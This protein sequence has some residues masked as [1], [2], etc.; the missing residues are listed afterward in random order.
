MSIF[1]F[2]MNIPKEIKN[3][4][5]KVK[6]AGFEIFVVGGSVRDLL[7]EKSDT[8]DWDLTTNAKPDEIL[9]IF[10]EG[11]YE[12]DFGTVL[13][14]IKSD[15]DEVMFVVEITTYRSE[16]GYSDRRHPDEV[17]FEEK[18]END[19]S[20]RDFTVNAIAWDGE[21]GEIIDLFGGKKD[22]RKKVIR[23]VGEPVDRFKED[24]LRMMRAIRFACQLGF[25][26]EEKTARGISKMAG[27]IKFI[28]KER[29]RDELVKILKSDKAYVG[30]M[31]LHDYKLLQYIIP[32]LEQGVGMEQNHHH[33]YSVFEHLALA[34]K[35]CPNKDW[36]VRFTAL[37]HDIGKPKTR[38]VVDGVVTFYNHEY[39]GAR[40]T[41]KILSRLK[42]SAADT[43]K[44]V[45]LVRNHM[46]YYNVG[47]VTESSVRRLIS[48]VGKEN[49]KDL[50][51]LRIAD[52]LGSGV[53]KAKPYKLRHLEYIM[54]KVQNDPV[55]VK[56]LKLNGDYMI[57]NLGF[58]PGPKMGAVLD[59]LLSE[60]LD[61]PARNTLDYLSQRALQLEQEDFN[62]LR[63]KAREAIGEKREEDDR[64][65]KRNYYVK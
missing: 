51:D 26:L 57:A 12:N 58:A 18:L 4:I 39:A 27:S 63:E 55:S 30:F 25:T 19:L 10:P 36:R 21:K 47:Q 13:V 33:T 42:F 11:K 44:I 40:M 9:K 8:G 24:A 59:I 37:L 65:I 52:R 61:D 54:E 16:S 48:K 46:F 23:A 6:T 60:V 20:R 34:L 28:A 22:I 49:L 17:V 38:K 53:P 31:M 3:I 50:I 14:P 62:A 5:N 29:I 32:E 56:M 35:N 64:K 2:I 43:E 15:T 7:L 41:E 45:N 1:Y